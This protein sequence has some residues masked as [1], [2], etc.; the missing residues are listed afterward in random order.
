MGTK[1]KKPRAMKSRKAGIKAQIRI[2]S[3]NKIL[4]KLEKEL[5]K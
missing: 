3:N 5:S 4:K 1:A 2:D